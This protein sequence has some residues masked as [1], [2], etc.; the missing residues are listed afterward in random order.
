ML[1]LPSTVRV[2]LATVPVDLRRG[3]DGLAALVRHVWKLDPLGGHLFVFVGRRRDRVK[4]LFWQ[5]GGYVLVYK[6]LERGRF[7]LPVVPAGATH[8]LIEAADLA[9]LLDGVDL[10][11]VRRT[12]LW[13]PPETAR[14]A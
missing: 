8:V 7:S 2:H 4:I 3:F 6:R 5:R 9:M 10:R 14:A 1:T 12:R 11:Q 13:S